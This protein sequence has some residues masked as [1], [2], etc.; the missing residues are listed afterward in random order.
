[1][2]AVVLAL[3][4]AASYGASDF[5][6]GLG[7]RRVSYVRVAIIAQM[8]G[9]GSV[10]LGASVAGGHLTL[11]GVGWGALSGIGAGTGSL[12]LYRGLGRGEMS[13]V[14]PISGVGSAVIPALAGLVLGERPPAVTLVGVAVIL[15]AVYLIAREADAAAPPGGDP[16]VG[17]RAGVVDGALAGVGFGGFFLALSQAGSGDGLWPSAASTVASTLLM[18]GFLLGR[19]HPHVRDRDRGAPSMVAD[20]P[21]SMAGTTRLTAVAAGVS[22]GA[23]SAL[24]LLATRRG[25][26]VVVAVLAALYPA[27]TVLLARAVLHERSARSQVVGLVMAAAA[28]VAITA[29]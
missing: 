5:L 24:Y 17:V 29:G 8:A 12:A 16:G 21:A 19:R 4:C 2:T 11:E 25:L 13:V 10:L 7:S 23:A 3:L 1:M 20:Q 26:L 27:V 18:L 6:G 9:M 28:V 15:P 14:G 22:A